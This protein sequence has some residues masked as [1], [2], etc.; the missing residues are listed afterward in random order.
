MMNAFVGE[1]LSVITSKV[2]TT[3]H[4]IMGIVNGDDFQIVYSDTP[5]ILKPNY[6]LQE[7]ML[8]FVSTALADADVILYVTDVVESF[9]KNERFI[10]K[11]KRS[12]APVLLL[13]NKIDI[14]DQETVQKLMNQW[15]DILPKA[16]IIPVSA[17]ENY[18]LD[19]VFDRIY[20]LLPSSPPYFPKDE[21]TDKTERFFVSEIIRG[22][23]FDNYQK[24]IPYSV[25]VE[26]ES[27][28][29]EKNIIRIRSIIYVLRDTQKGIMIGN[30]GRALK[31]TGTEAR[32]DIEQF[33]NK[34]VYLELFVK[35]KKNWRDD[36]KQLKNFG[37]Q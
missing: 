33:F 23:I 24:E 28:K 25:E 35:V 10:E 32:K 9:D 22:K 2:Q 5:G 15:Q 14:S 26:V 1:K 37:Y 8:K 17:L 31:K 3:R 34:K 11:I 19:K 27:F 20:E 12:K 18:N 36:P 6:K 21:L 7:S 30:Q 16:E 29:E 4:R 13:I